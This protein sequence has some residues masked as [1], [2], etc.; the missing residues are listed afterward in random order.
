MPAAKGSKENPFHV[1][2]D[3]ETLF[4]LK[5]GDIV[6][7]DITSFDIRREAPNDPKNKR[8]VGDQVPDYQRFLVTTHPIVRNGQTFLESRQGAGELVTFVGDADHKR[9]AYIKD[10]L[11]RIWYKRQALGNQPE[12]SPTLPFV[13]THATEW[14]EC[15]RE[16]L[17][18]NKNR[19]SVNSYEQHRAGLISGLEEDLVLRDVAKANGYQIVRTVR[20]DEYTTNKIAAFAGLKDSIERQIRAR[21]DNPSVQYVGHPGQYADRAL[22]LLNRALPNQALDGRFLSGFVEYLEQTPMK[23]VGKARTPDTLAKTITD[24]YL[25]DAFQ[26]LFNNQ[27]GTIKEAFNRFLARVGG[28]SNGTRGKYRQFLDKQFGT[29]QRRTLVLKKI[30]ILHGEVDS[31]LDQGGYEENADDN[32]DDEDTDE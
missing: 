18:L 16:F 1:V 12:L 5:S 30:A 26:V 11:Q 29:A 31:S 21:D 28:S 25:V 17:L 13:I 32:Y 8:L 9:G 3:L 22:R 15:A 24:D 19:A 14:K 7:V 27:Q 4:T 10:G 23:Q 20:A 6:Y 2:E